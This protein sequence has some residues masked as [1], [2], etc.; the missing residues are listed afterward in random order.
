MLL[1]HYAVALAGKTYAPR[2]NL[3]TLVAAAIFLDLIWPVFLSLGWESVVI[4]PG[5]TAVTPLDFAHYPW[6]HSLLTSIVW[7]AGVGGLYY[8]LRREAPGARMVG[9]LVIS[10]W[11]LDLVVHRPDLPLLPWGDI[12]LGLGLW[13][14]LPA[15]AL[16]EFGLLA[17]GAFLYA[18][19]TRARDAAGRWGLVCLIGLLA[20]IYTV[21][22]MGPPPPGV[23]AII[24]A[25]AAQ[26]LFIALA[27]W[28][29][30][31]RAV[32]A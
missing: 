13:N 19:A 16:V 12:K 27:A 31:R 4:A 2:T 29:D 9:L 23:P 18:R 5:D 7:G 20:L 10:H 6:S 21:N 14:F 15:T 25:D 17:V 26:L 32:R 24:V 22:L 30:S 3:G 28:V 1:G 8:L 11:L